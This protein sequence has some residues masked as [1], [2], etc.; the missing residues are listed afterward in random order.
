M[1]TSEKGKAPQQPQVSDLIER[2][3]PLVQELR[4][5]VAGLAQYHESPEAQEKA[6]QLKEIC[7]TITRL[8]SLKVAVPNELRNLKTDLVGELSVD[9]QVRE[10]FVALRDGLVEVLDAI[11]QRLGKPATGDKPR[12]KRSH[13]P[14]TEKAV[15]REYL[16]R[17]L[18]AKGG[19]ASIHE[20]LAWMEEHLR[21][22]LQPG[23]LET[24]STGEVVWQNNTCWERFNLIQEG[25]LKPDS[26]RGIWELNDDHR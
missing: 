11:Q 3:D 18:K 22:R 21:D 25:I 6:E 14:R 2:A 4:Q 16:L 10:A 12:R 13:L 26:P 17:A 9:E 24:R 20:V 8:E 23:D 1:D 19:R 7:R 5:L 15:L